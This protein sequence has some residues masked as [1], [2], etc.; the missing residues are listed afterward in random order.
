[1]ERVQANGNWTLMCPNECP[2]MELLHGDEFR[3][4][5]ETYE[6]EKKGRK[7]ISLCLLPNGNLLLM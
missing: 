4:L 7:T 6:K 1:M 5:Y 3:E 2:G